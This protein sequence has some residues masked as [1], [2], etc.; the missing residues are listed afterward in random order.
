MTADHRAIYMAY[1]ALDWRRE[2]IPLPQQDGRI[3]LYARALRARSTPH[4]DRLAIALVILD[5]I[6]AEHERFLARRPASRARHRR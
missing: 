6:T 2:T 4:P 5:W 1:K 3:D